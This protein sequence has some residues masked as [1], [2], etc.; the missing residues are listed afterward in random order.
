[1]SYETYSLSSGNGGKRFVIFAKEN[2]PLMVYLFLQRGPKQ[3]EIFVLQCQILSIFPEYY[4][5]LTL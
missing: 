2:I 3:R 4:L 5:Q 1:M